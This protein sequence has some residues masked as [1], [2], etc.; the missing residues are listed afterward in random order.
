MNNEKTRIK[1]SLHD[2]T[3]TG[4]AGADTLIGGARGADVI[5]TY[6]AAQAAN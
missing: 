4:G 2:D 6:P 3:L 1:K 5:T